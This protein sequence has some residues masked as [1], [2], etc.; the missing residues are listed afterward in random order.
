MASSPIVISRRHHE[1]LWG[2]TIAQWFR[3]LGAWPHV[4]LAAALVGAMASVYLYQISFVERQIDQ[5]V[6][7]ESDLADLNQ[8]NNELSVSI[9][10]YEDMSR[11]KTEA[12]AMGLGEA[13]HI[14]YLDVVLDGSTAQDHVIQGL[15]ASAA[16]AGQSSA[17]L[18]D[19]TLP[20]SGG[21]WVAS[22]IVQQFRGWI[23]RGTA[24]LGETQ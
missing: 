6:R 20:T 19:E 7:F 21:S 3:G 12:R 18:E 1:G 4:L 22:T 5:M 11:I 24:A 9:A 8:R 23:D 13:T 16:S 14:E 17:W 10:G 2:R 15:S